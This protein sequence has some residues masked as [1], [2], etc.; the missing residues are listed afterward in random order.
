MHK[1][2]IVSILISAFILSITGC[3]I[4][5][6]HIGDEIGFEEVSPVDDDTKETIGNYD[7]TENFNKEYSVTDIEALRVHN[8]VGRVY[9]TGEDSNSVIVSYTKKVKTLNHNEEV[10]KEALDSIHVKSE[11][12]DGVIEISVDLDKDFRRLFQTRSVDFEIIVP[13]RLLN[14]KV[15]N[16]VG[17]V[18]LTGI[19]TDIM[20]SNVSVGD[21]KIY[22]SR[23]VKSQ[24][25]TST[26]KII[27][28]NTTIGGKI[29]ASTGSIV[30]E[31]GIIL[32]DSVVETSTGSIDVTSGLEEGGNYAFESK[33]GS[34]TLKVHPDYSFQLDAETDV[35][36]VECSLLLNDVYSKKGILRGKTFDGKAFIKLR[37][38]VGSIHVIK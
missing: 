26:G 38:S 24:I 32:S 1:K 35:G 5:V 6:N 25:S 29:K 31:E 34:I 3:T 13:R 16:N 7:G 10:I 23:I 36:D 21:L 4:E 12:K 20:Y 28:S 19:N 8:L 11:E 17:D 33:T 37:S 15:V 9:V 18:M 22:D 14:I 27:T 30:M 2:F